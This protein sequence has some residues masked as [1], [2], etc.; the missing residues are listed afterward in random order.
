MAHIILSVKNK[1]HKK[2]KQPTNISETTARLD[3]MYEK[4]IKDS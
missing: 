4:T 1:K 2:N 3:G